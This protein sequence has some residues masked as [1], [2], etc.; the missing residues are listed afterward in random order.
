M[1]NNGAIMP[2]PGY[3][4]T[5]RELCIRYDVLLM[6]DEVITGFRL[7]LGGAQERFGVTPDIAT[8][9]KGIAGGFT[10]SAI[11]GKRSVMERCGDLSVLHAG[12]YNS[13]PPCM[14]AV[15]ASLEELSANNGAVY[16]QIEARGQR[17]ME[18]IREA[19]KR[20]HKP[21]SVR[22]LPAVFSVT[23]GQMEP[24]TDYRSFLK[25]DIPMQRRYFALLQD[26]GVR[27]TPDQLN[28]VSTAHTE[29]DIDQT[30]AAVDEAM[31]LL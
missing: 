22:G 18:G 30:L 23:F 11:A 28:F 14:A 7:S 25:R 9:A 2:L 6:F 12:T 8:F 26:R 10:V 15:L 16:R 4:E 3:L 13:N 27:T 1:C 21:V 20:H 29:E 24:V 19:G 5:V 31:R 17:L